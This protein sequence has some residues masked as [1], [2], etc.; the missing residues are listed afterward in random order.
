MP[1]VLEVLYSPGITSEDEIPPS[2][3][4]LRLKEAKEVAAF[5]EKEI[6]CGCP[7][8]HAHTLVGAWGALEAAI[9]DLV[10]G[11]LMNEPNELN[12]EAFSNIR[13]PLANFEALEKEDRMRL[14][15]EEVNRLNSS[16]RSQG[17]DAFERLLEKFLL[18]GAVK[19]ETKKDIWEMNNVRN[20][21]VH[22]NSIADRR[23]VKNCPWLNLKPGDAVI[24][25]H[26]QLDRYGQ[27]LCDYALTITHRL[28]T[29]YGVD[30]EAKI[31]R[32]L[33][34]QKT[35]PSAPDEPV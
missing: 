31:E 14:L 34:S 8:L 22:R 17:I 10:L 26:D 23:L 28:G 6:A 18:S 9:E 27:A 20:V 12:N 32:V 15:I 4:R 3:R 16:H 30:I 24:V 1:R 7:L 2:K 21:I 5:A 13:V 33:S 11:I 19:A 35:L 29:R 25:T